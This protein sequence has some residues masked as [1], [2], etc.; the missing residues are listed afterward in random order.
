MR[1]FSP[2]EAA[3]A[4]T[5]RMPPVERLDFERRAGRKPRAKPD[6]DDLEGPPAATTRIRGA[7]LAWRMTP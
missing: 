2:A 3:L 4:G 6:P 1:L 7:A 5:W